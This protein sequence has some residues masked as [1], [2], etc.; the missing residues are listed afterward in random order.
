[1]TRSRRA[2]DGAASGAEILGEEVNTMGGRANKAL[3]RRVKKTVLRRPIGRRRTFFVFARKGKG[4]VQVSLKG[5]AFLCAIE[6]GM[7]QEIPNGGYDAEPFL[8][9][10]SELSKFIRAD[11]SGYPTEIRNVIEFIQKEKGQ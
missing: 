8:M 9:F 10:W 11:C 6:A 5:L 3:C 7:V 4:A 1:M 2:R